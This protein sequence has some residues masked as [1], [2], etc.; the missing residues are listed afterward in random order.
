MIKL[1]SKEEQNNQE[2]DVANGS[3]PAAPSQS[4][5]WGR[6]STSQKNRDGVQVRQHLGLDSDR[7]LTPAIASP[8]CFKAFMPRFSR[9]S[10][11]HGGLFGEDQRA[12]LPA[13]CR[14]GS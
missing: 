10:K 9:S 5:I 2:K 14:S 3:H 4:C 12:R 8:V 13:S 11:T 7:H 6:V 1:F